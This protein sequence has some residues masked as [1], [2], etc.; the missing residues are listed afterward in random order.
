MYVTLLMK[1]K[2]KMFLCFN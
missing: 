2:L 1:A